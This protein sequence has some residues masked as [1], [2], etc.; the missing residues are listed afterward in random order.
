M[1]T[2]RRSGMGSSSAFTVGL[3]HALH[4]LKGQMVSKHELAMEAIHVEQDLLKETVGSQ[5]QV[6][7]AY[8]GLSHVCFL[9]GGEVSVRPIIMPFERMQLFNAHVMLFYTGI[10]RTASTVASTYVNDIGRHR[11]QLRMIQNLVD[12]GLALLSSDKDIALFGEL[13]HEAW[14]AKQSLSKQVSNDRVDDIYQ[15]A[16]A[17]GAIGGKLLGAGG[18][19]FIMFFVPPEQRESVK[20]R[21]QG[22][23]HVPCKFEFSGSQIVFYNVEQD[24]SSE[25]QDRQNHRID[26]FRELATRRQ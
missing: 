4:A 24:Y 26:P 3:L 14:Q 20:Q 17:A 2:C 16:R 15:E 11:P 7:A 18:G 21:L 1:P 25:D 10:K 13:L 12:E 8:G 6:L 23:I 5:D 19:G 22:L 9:P